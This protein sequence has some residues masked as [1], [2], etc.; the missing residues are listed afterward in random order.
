MDHQSDFREVCAV[1]LVRLLNSWFLLSV[2]LIFN[3]IRF[4][5]DD[6]VVSSM[7]QVI[8]ILGEDGSDIKVEVTGED[9][10]PDLFPISAS[11]ETVLNYKQDDLEAF[12]IDVETEDGTSHT[13]TLP[14]INPD[15]LLGT[16]LSPIKT[17]RTREDSISGVMNSDG[18]NDAIQIFQPNDTDNL[19]TAFQDPLTTIQ[20][21]HA[22]ESGIYAR[23][24]SP[25]KCNLSL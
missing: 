25:I 11:G 9:N 4:I 21:Q 19:Q 7:Q 3:F 24:T 16:N 23:D 13:I 12:H 1:E 8:A 14:S 6:Q 5:S 18:N 20:I 2:K 22:N 15:D 10:L 17:N